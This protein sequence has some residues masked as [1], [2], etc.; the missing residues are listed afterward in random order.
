MG[1]VLLTLTFAAPK[2]QN[3]SQTYNILVSPTRIS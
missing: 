1:T 2:P 3:A